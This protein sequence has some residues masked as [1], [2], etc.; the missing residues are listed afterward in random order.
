M[1][2]TLTA[3]GIEKLRAAPYRRE[4]PDGGCAGLFLI[5]QSSG[6]KSFALRARRPDGRN[7]KLTLGQFTPIDTDGKPVI[8]APLTLHA[9]RQLAIELQ[10]DR[11]RGVDVVGRRHTERL[12]LH[13]NGG[14]LFG[15][16]AIDFIEQHAKRETRR[17]QETARRLGLN[18]VGDDVLEVIPKGLADRWRD[19]AVTEINSD[20]VFALVEECRERG[21]PG[22]EARNEGPS[23]PRALAMHATLSGLF[24]WL[25]AKRRVKANPVVGLARPN[26]AKSRERVLKDAEL[27]RFWRAAEAERIEFAVPLKLLLLTGCR[28]NEVVGMRRDELSEDGATWIIPGTRTKNHREHVVPLPP[29]AREI[30]ASVSVT[31]GFVFSTTKGRRPVTLGSRVKN[32]IDAAM[33]VDDWILH[34]LR[35]TAATGMAEIGIAPHIVEAAL[36][37]VSGVR[38][39]VAGTY[40]RAQYSAEKKQALERWASHIAGLVSGK[41]AKVH[42]L[43]TA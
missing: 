5:I 9:A 11:A 14:K 16:S 40:N 1:A 19:R 18:P 23:E 34:D 20:D 21:F 25:L 15:Q 30:L 36:N 2:K 33:G 35:R 37:H 7:F 3:R 41:V 43:R 6:F 10:R 29:L 42:T 13:S 38:A 28:L 12:A 22:L 4:I 32:H 26:K 31:D 17:W 39:G 27:V 24:A 8:G